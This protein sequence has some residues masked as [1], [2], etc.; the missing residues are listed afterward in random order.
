MT[1]KDAKGNYSVNPDATGNPDISVDTNN[2]A[3]YLEA[4]KIDGT[5]ITF[6]GDTVQLTDGFESAF[7]FNAPNQFPKSTALITTKQQINFTKDFSLNAT[8]A[9]NWN[10]QM[11]DQSW[12]YGG[13]GMG[14]MF[15]NVSPD[16][17]VKTAQEGGGIGISKLD[18]NKIA[19]IISTNAKKR[20][21]KGQ[22]R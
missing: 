20:V 6:N 17:A 3:Q 2:I 19:Y 16:Q 10:K 21:T 14:L 9:I 7:S 11:K 5:P 13:D 1:Q 4:H 12:G 15:E 18:V 8:I 22:L